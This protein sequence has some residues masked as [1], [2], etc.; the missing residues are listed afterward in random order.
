LLRP[1]LLDLHVERFLAWLAVGAWPGLATDA[2]EILREEAARGE[3]R[4]AHVGLAL[5]YWR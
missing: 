4:A 5:S 1:Q 2:G 3:I